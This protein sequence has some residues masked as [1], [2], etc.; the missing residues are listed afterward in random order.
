MASSPKLTFESC[1][2]LAYPSKYRQLLGTPGHGPFFSSKNPLTLHAYSA[3]DWA[4]DFD[5]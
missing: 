1:I 4:G 5:D 3:T 2:S